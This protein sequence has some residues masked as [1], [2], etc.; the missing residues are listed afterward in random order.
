MEGTSQVNGVNLWYRIT[1]EG[2]PVVQI[3]GAGFGHFNFD[4]ATPELSKHFRVVDYDMRGY[5]AVGPAGP[6]LR[7]G[8]LGGRPRR[9]DGRARDRRR[10]TSTAPRWAG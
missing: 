2:E 8:G 9:P 7:H 1:G 3:H 5:G 10:R 6:G 4:P